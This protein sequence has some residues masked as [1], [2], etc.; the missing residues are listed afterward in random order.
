VASVL[1]VFGGWAI[2]SGVTQLVAAL[3]RHRP[4]PGKQWSLLLA[5]ALSVLVGGG[6]ASPRS[7]TIRG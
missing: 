2:V 1:L 4:E 6:S 7:A 3:H 5:G